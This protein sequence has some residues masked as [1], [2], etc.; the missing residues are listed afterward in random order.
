MTRTGEGHRPWVGRVGIV[1]AV[2]LAI[3]AAGFA[4]LRYQGRRGPVARIR[5]LV[6]RGHPGA[7]IPAIESFGRAHPERKSAVFFLEGY[8][9]AGQGHW[10][11]AARLYDQALTASPP[12]GSRERATIRSQLVPRLMSDD[13]L[14]RTAA[15]RTLAVLGDASVA[16]AL[17]AALAAE[18]RRPKVPFG[19]KLCT[20]SEEA[21]KALALLV[22]KG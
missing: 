2:G 11:R 22:P 18:A 20:F 3:A 12:V 1:V 13:C 4:V 14:T 19:K 5:A 7:A 17:R 6:D 10:T 21:K 9:A 8:T 15:A 16:G